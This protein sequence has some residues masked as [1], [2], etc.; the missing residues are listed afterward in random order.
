[1]TQEIIVA[2]TF[3]RIPL[4]LAVSSGVI[5]STTAAASAGIVFNNHPGHRVRYGLVRRMRV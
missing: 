4:I 5:A 3:H 1:M 2:K